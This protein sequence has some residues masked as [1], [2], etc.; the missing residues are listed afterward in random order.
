M[1]GAVVVEQA[2]SGEDL[3]GGGDI[4]AIPGQLEDVSGVDLCPR[5]VLEDLQE[6]QGADHVVP[7]PFAP[8]VPGRV[9]GHHRF[10]I[11]D[12]V[13]LGCEGAGDDERGVG[14]Q[15]E[16]DQLPPPQRLEPRRH[17]RSSGPFGRGLEPWGAGAPEAHVGQEQLLA[18]LVS[19]H[20]V[21]AARFLG[22]AGLLEAQPA[23]KGF[24][25]SGMAA[26]MLAIAEGVMG[27]P[28]PAAPAEEAIG[29]VYPPRQAPPARAHVRRP[30]RVAVL[31]EAL[32]EV[33]ART[34]PAAR[35]WRERPTRQA[36]IAVVDPGPGPSDPLDLAAVAAAGGRV[37][38]EAQVLLSRSGVLRPAL[39]WRPY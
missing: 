36:V 7:L 2:G 1:G 13:A 31:A 28:P 9:L 35:R 37:T 18:V 14:G 34:A 39:C 22:H 33:A 4:A 21:R 23:G 6:P 24:A 8:T 12:Q 25:H 30:T 15:F 38:E 16:Q 10:A 19:G 29:P 27:V 32:T 26:A 17:C 3:K 20:Q 5:C 11:G